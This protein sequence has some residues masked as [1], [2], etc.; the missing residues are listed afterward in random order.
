MS[1]LM[2]IDLLMLDAMLFKIFAE[3]VLICKLLSFPNKLLTTTLV[4]RPIKLP[5]ILESEVKV[6]IPT[7]VLIP[8]TDVVF[9]V[10]RDIRDTAFAI[11]ETAFAKLDTVS[12]LEL[13]DCV[14]KFTS[15]DIVE[16]VDPR[17]SP[18]D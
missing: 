6:L 5:I 10:G 16:S 12:D 3:F 13:K 15:P 17:V 11:E 4:V 7:L 8:R 2:P 18:I 14:K 1:E 9:K